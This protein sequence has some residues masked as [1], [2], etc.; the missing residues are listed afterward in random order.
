MKKRLILPWIFVF[1]F[2]FINSAFAVDNE[3]VV[4]SPDKNVQFILNYSDKLTYTVERNGSTIIS[5][6]NLGLVIGGTSSDTLTEGTLKHAASGS[7]RGKIQTRL[8]EKSEWNDEYN[9]AIFFFLN[10]LVDSFEIEVRVYNE[11]F[12]FRYIIDNF[13]I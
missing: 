3:I 2:S 7:Y 1:L 4:L 9:Y 5:E 11:G 10:E 13:V 6:S 8:G 12:A